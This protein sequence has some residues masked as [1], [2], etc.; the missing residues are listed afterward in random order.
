MNNLVDVLMNK[1]ILI[2]DLND[3]LFVRLLNNPE[4]RF[5]CMEQFTKMPGF[6]EARMDVEQCNDAVTLD[7]VYEKMHHS[8]Q[9]LKEVETNL[10]IS[11]T[12][13]NPD[14]KNL[15]E[16]A[17]RRNI[18]VYL[19]NNT[20]ISNVIIEAFLKEN[21]CIG[22]SKL[23]AV[24]Y[25][26]EKKDMY[27][28]IM[29]ENSASPADI[30]Y[31]TCSSDNGTKKKYDVSVFECESILRRYGQNMNS[32]FFAT[33]NQ[34]RKDD[35]WISVLEN[36]IALSKA[37]K[38]I[39]DDWISFGYKYIGILA[40][41][42]AKY[43][44]ETSKKLGI[45]KLFFLDE[46]SYCLKIAV[47]VLYPNIESESLSCLE[48]ENQKNPLKEDEVFSESVGIVDIGRH[49][50]LLSGLKELYRNTSAKHGPL[51]FWW[52]YTPKVCWKSGLLRN[53]KDSSNRNEEKS[54][55][56]L[57]HIFKLAL[58][59]PCSENTRKIFKGTIDCVRDLQKINEKCELAKNQ[60]GMQAVCEY[61]QENI[62]WRDRALLEQAYSDSDTIDHGCMKPIFR[63]GKPV[64]GIANPWPE[65]VSAEAEVITRI[66]R[67]AEENGIECVLLDGF[68]HILND[69]QGQ[70]K[71]IIKDED[72]SFI[73]TTHYE[74]AKVRN[75]FYYNPLWNPPEIP[76]NLSDYATRV[77]N[78]FMMN[79][80][81]LIYD[82]GGMSNHLRSMLMNCPRTIEGASALTASFPASAA[83]KPK[84][85]KPIMFYC[86]MNWEVMFGGEGRHDGLFKLLDDTKK[87]EFYGPERVEAWGGLKPWEGYHCY[88]GMIPFDGFSILKKINECGVC[89]VLSSDTH[90]RAGAATNRLYE[91]CAAGAV[92][93]SDDNE[94][95]VDHFKDAALFITFNKNDPIDTFHQIMEKY[96]WIVDHPEEALEL[97]HRA[98]E[99]YLK[100][101][102]L[103][104]Q[105]NQ[106]I[107]HHP[108]RFK[109]L[110]KDL[111]AQDE[112]G[113]VLVTF[114]LNTQRVKEASKWLDCVIRNLHG[115]LY[116]NMELA[117]AADNNVASEIIEYCNTRCAC[118]YVVS[119][120]LFDA[121][122]IRAMTD[123]EA[124][125]RL[126]NEIPHDYY[127][128][129][130]ADEVWFFDHITSL[131]RAINKDN[132]LCAYSGAAFEDSSGIRHI[133]FFDVMNTSYLYHMN[134]PSHPLVAGQFLFKAR[135]HEFLPDYLFGN[136]DG[137]EHLAYCGIGHYC[138]NAE[139]AFTKRMSLVCFANQ[140]DE[141]GSVL[142]DVMQCRFIQDLLRFHIPE[143][144]LEVS[145]NQENCQS[146]GVN[147]QELSDYMLYMPLKA[148][149]RLRYYRFQLRRKKLGSK[150]YKKYAAKYDA[151]LEKYQQYWNM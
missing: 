3:A 79:D 51:V 138:H 88:Q 16:E 36:N 5:G 109:Q 101:Y 57:Q 117:I 148:Y 92:I 122:G 99:I 65:D 8:Y 30:L 59:R 19:C 150:S 54:I 149:I 33:L 49:M 118:A 106:I 18:S 4:D 35:V 64:I 53:I 14:I 93:I 116:Q 105:L 58:S 70:T 119:M 137:K 23:Y 10:I 67:T 44:G 60:K 128:N 42:Y 81:F 120:P 133:N 134:K 25:E 62:D 40:F 97:A 127:I 90:R 95:V 143:T 26:E 96:E 6:F 22:Y 147:K 124:I 27:Q 141:R 61:F 37:L 103:D 21:D 130:T 112:D 11:T 56:Y 63:Q 108:S 34:Y 24:R 55:K 100:E 75:V 102:S 72:L 48:L 132:C 86:G 83:L 84:L 131:V 20:G 80:D 146:N 15:F 52:E 107:N 28:E 145:T 7:D 110:S 73:I 32:A 121:K 71:K 76:L 139:L 31:V 69:K 66:K 144:V 1:T 111:Y 39:D 126:Q 142:S 123:G 12:R 136:L 114:V 115:Q 43:I 89:L 13:I 82:N 68:G 2:L 91:A 78:Q 104:V 94:F 98:Q 17:I 29:Q 140:E 46:T 77:T 135:S 38:K 47:E 87:V 45:R 85:D 151:Y 113:K 129:T 125:R 74:C 50:S 9:T 41:E